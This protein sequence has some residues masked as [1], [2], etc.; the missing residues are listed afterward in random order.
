MA[1]KHLIAGQGAQ[2]ESR[3]VADVVDFNQRDIQLSQVLYDYIMDLE[4]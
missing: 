2:A 4:Q 1:A 3:Q